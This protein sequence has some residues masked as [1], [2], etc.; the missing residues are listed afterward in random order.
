MNVKNRCGYRG[1]AAIH[2]RTRPPLSSLG[3][4]YYSGCCIWLPD[5]G[6]PF[7]GSRDRRIR[8]QRP[9]CSL[10]GFGVVYFELTVS[11]EDIVAAGA[12]IVYDLTFPLVVTKGLHVFVRNAFRDP[13]SIHSVKIEKIY[14]EQEQFQLSN[15][16]SNH[17]IR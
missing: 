1:A 14:S 16:T 6:Q 8:L 15:V 11:I 2:L 9:R 4:R 12:G 5:I 13:A 3:T 7:C 17:N 10:H